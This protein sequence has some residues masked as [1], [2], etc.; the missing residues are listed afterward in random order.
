MKQDALWINTQDKILRVSL[1]SINCS[2]CVFTVYGILR[3]TLLSKIKTLFTVGDLLQLHG[4]SCTV[5]VAEVS[6]IVAGCQNPRYLPCWREPL[7]AQEKY[8]IFI[9]PL[10]KIQINQRRSWWYWCCK[11]ETCVGMRHLLG[12]EWWRSTA[13]SWLEPTM[14]MSREKSCSHPDNKQHL[15]LSPNLVGRKK[16]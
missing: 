16:I 3:T 9:S 10:L 12:Q 2:S 1:Q 5:E 15:V 7:P 13:T 8:G 4:L 14:S 6:L 11:D